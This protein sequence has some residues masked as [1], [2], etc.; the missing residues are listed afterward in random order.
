MMRF[1]LIAGEF[2][3]GGLAES[4]RRLTQKNNSARSSVFLTGKSARKLAERLS[5]LRGA[6]MKLGQLLSMEGGDVLPA[7]FSEALA[8]LRA[9]ADAM[10]EEQLRRLMG[11]EYGKGW[12]SRFTEFDYEPIA[13]ASIGQ[14]HYARAVDGRHMALKVQYPGVAR[15]IGSDVDNVAVLLRMLNILPVELDVSSLMAEAKR[16]LHQEADYLQEAANLKHYRELVVDDPLLWVPRVHADYSTRRVLAMDYANGSPI[17]ELGEPG[18]PQSLRDRV[19]HSLE[20]LLFRE[21]FEFRFMQTDPNFANYLYDFERDRLALLDL[22]AARRF[23]TGFTRRFAQVTQA[24]IDDDRT[25]IRQGAIDIGYLRDDDPRPRSEAAIDLIMLICEPLRHRGPYDFGTSDL[26][27]RAHESGI[28]LAFEKGYLR[29]PPAET[30]FLHR[31]LIGSFLLCA[32]I[33][34]RVDVNALIK[35]CLALY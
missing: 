30:V 24:I 34:A 35:P 31:K 19:G 33:R 15:S 27:A 28:E 5:H 8:V 22:G 9:R 20:R 3:A 26:P 6:A 21:L 18:T 13:A 32:R 2:A 10:P 12:E 14:V 25:G 16:Q 29:A 23:E 1:G 7:E 11:R 4:A 17:D